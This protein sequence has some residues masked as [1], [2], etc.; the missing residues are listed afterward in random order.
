MPRESET[1]CHSGVRTATT[2]SSSGSWL[3]GKNVPLKMNMGMITKRKRVAKGASLVCAAEKAWM[4]AAK[5]RPVRIVTG[6]ISRAWGR[7]VA[8]KA[9]I[10]PRKTTPPRVTR[11]PAHSSWPVATCRG[12]SGER[13]MPTYV[14][15][16]RMPAMTG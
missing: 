13:I 2:C 16:Q 8:P 7:S 10:T 15:S 3:M 6:S 11:T 9:I 14:L 4:G 1:A 12:S 5:A